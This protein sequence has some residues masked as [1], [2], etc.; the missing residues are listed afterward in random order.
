MDYMK[1]VD[2]ISRTFQA[3]REVKFQA[4]HDRK[5]QVDKFLVE[6]NLPGGAVVPYRIHLLGHDLDVI[7]GKKY[8][9]SLDFDKWLSAFEYELE[10]KFLTNVKL[11][12]S[13]DATDYRIR[14]PF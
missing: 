11:A 4:V 7:I 10:Q 8:F 5:D 13:N 3:A 14:L 1:V 12:V 6:M 2:V 9:D